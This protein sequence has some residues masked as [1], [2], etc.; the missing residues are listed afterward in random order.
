MNPL[1]ELEE[2]FCQIK[3][4]AINISEFDFLIETDFEVMIKKL[5]IYRNIKLE[6]LTF[7]TVLHERAYYYNLT[8]LKIVMNVTN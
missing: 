3:N 6:I 4:I 5:K 2:I 7:C 8:F 1:I